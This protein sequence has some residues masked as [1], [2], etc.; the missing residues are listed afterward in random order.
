MGGCTFHT[1]TPLAEGSI[2]RMGLQLSSEVAPVDVE[3]AVIRNVNP[4]RAGVEFLRIENAERERLQN[5]VR[6]LTVSR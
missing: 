3:A 4:G 5:F 2:V 6:G 1:E